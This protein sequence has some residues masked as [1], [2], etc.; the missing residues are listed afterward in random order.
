DV[1][2]DRLSSRMDLRRIMDQQYASISETES[3]FDN[4]YGTALS[5]IQSQRAVRA[6]RLED[7]KPQLRERYGMTRFGQ[8]LLLA[9]R[10]VEAETRFIQVTWPARSDDEPMPG[11][12]GSWDTHRNN[13]TMLRD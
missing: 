9:R 7:E 2:L 13:F 11:P 5:L 4:F 6:F 12:D 10:L 1:P 3:T 8:S